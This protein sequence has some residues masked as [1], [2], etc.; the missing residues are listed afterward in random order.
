M[1]AFVETPPFNY[2]LLIWMLN[3]RELHIHVNNAYKG[4]VGLRGVVDL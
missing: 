2:L 4:V 3:N 1:K